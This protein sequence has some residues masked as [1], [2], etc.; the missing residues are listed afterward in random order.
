MHV[1]GE[2]NLNILYYNNCW[3]TNVGEAFI[4]IGSMELIRSIFEE[5]KI[6]N[7]SNMSNWYI[8]QKCCDEK[9]QIGEYNCLSMCDYY[10]G[11]YIIFSGMFASEEFLDSITCT[12]I[13]ELSKKG[14]KI[15]FLGLGQCTYT[16]N[17]T[18]RFREFINQ[19][20]LELI[21]SRD[22]VVY[23]NFKDIVPCINGIDCAFWV[24][25]VYDPRCKI[26]K[27]YDVVTYNRST[28]PKNL[29]TKNE[30]IRAYHLQYS[31]NIKKLRPNMLISDTPY[32]YLTLY[33]NAENVYTDLVHA[34]IASLQFGKHVKFDR[35]DKRAY[36]IDAL[37]R[38]GLSEDEQGKYYI[39]EKILDLEKERIMNEI[40]EKI[41]F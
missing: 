12:M 24:K 37:N 11:D 14:V 21:V 3:F 5:S 13:K 41:K 26:L 28:E 34:T 22:E 30:V 20:N 15:I 27:K 9:I 32:D 38:I 40:K 23:Q 31:F 2:N 7:I 6:I 35:V 17:E 25:N 29:N 39:D 1:L 10:W 16:E 4:D 8:S 33:A 18:K 19:I 36:A